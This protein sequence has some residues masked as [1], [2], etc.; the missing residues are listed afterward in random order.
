MVALVR[1]VGKH[2]LCSITLALSVLGPACSGTTPCASSAL[3]T[4]GEV[5]AANGACAPLEREAER[6]SRGVWLSVRDFGVTARTG[7]PAVGPDTDLLLLGG[8]GD[9]TIYLAFGPLPAGA[10]IPKAILVLSPHETFTPA[11]DGARIAAFAV[12]PFRGDDLSR[13]D[14]PRR[15]PEPSA[16]AVLAPGMTRRVRLDLTTQV[17][18][19]HRLGAEIVS[20]ALLG[21]IEGGEVP[22]RFASPWALDTARR[23]RLELSVR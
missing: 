8:S 23:P 7:H 14:A 17:E 18:H 19:A 13:R 12:R 4:N 21:E 1:R 20:V 9:H 2:T 22:L 16:E 6:F 11:P 15:E 5:C 3:C 10:A